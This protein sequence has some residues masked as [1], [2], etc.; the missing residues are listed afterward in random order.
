MPN[1]LVTYDQE[2]GLVFLDGRLEL[3]EAWRRKLAQHNYQSTLRAWGKFSKDGEATRHQSYQQHIG[4]LADAYH[5]AI[6]HEI[7]YVIGRLEQLL[8]LESGTIDQAI[9][10]AIATHDLGK[11][12][13]KWQHWARAWQHL[14]SAKTGWANQ[15]HEP[16]ETYFFAKTDY[17]YRSKEQRDWQKEL[18]EKR[19]HHACESVMIGKKLLATSLGITSPRS[20]NIPV[21]RAV[22]AAIARHH[23]PQA[24]EY[25]ETRLDAR[26][27]Q[28][29]KEAVALVQRDDAWN[30][31]SELLTLAFGKGQLEAAN[32]NR[33]VLTRPD[34]FSSQEELYETW[35]YF[36]IVRA[37]R[38]ADQ[39]ADLFVSFRSF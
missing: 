14:V 29:F 28:A 27:I 38:L 22:C 13:R 5:Y 2:L 6:R 10:L 4:G 36:V 25:G 26:A 30:Y 1:S 34:M 33:S 12:D 16:G 7:V 21:L 24:R 37:L 3:P 15:Y 20:P 8:G 23:T 17:D 9:Q 32:A 31:E 18:A 11:L 35:L 39:R 19:P